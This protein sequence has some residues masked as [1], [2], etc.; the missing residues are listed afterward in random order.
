MR[1]R[2]AD[3]R[4]RVNA[5]LEFRFT[6]PGL[7]SYAGL[8]LLRRYVATIGLVHQLRRYLTTHVPGTEVRL[9][10]ASARQLLSRTF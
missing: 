7:T 10:R 1:L 6:S 5:N 2:K 3:L 8:E 9:P 4:G